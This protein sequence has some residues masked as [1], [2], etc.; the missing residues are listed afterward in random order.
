M[1][2]GLTAN[3]GN[4]MK[5]KKEHFDHMRS[6]IERVLNRY[7]DLVRGYEQ[8][9]FPGADKVH[10]LQTRFNHDLAFGAGLSK[11]I[12]DNL[13]PYLEDSHIKTALNKICPTLE[14]K[15]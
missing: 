9:L 15:F 2:N 8:G 10:D 13:Y 7:P 12:C 4:K 14:R 11:F 3:R 6:E 1:T 5:M